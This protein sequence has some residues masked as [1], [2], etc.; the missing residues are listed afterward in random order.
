MQR[1]KGLLLSVFV[2]VSMFTT[3]PV[4][5]YAEGSSDA[6]QVLEYEVLEDDTIKITQYDSLDKCYDIP[7]TI[8]GK[9]V[10][11]I[12]KKA[13]AGCHVLTSVTIPDTVITI[14]NNAFEKCDKLTNVV[15]GNSVKTLGYRAFADNK[16]L[17][18]INLPEGLTTIDNN[19]FIRC[20]KLESIKIPDSVSLIG[21]SAFSD[22][23]GL[24]T[25]NFGNGETT[26]GESAF[27]W[28]LAL[29]E[30]I[31]SKNTVEIKDNAFVACDNVKK[32]T[33]ESD[34]CIIFDGINTL[35]E[36]TV[37]YAYEGSTAN[38]YAI[39]YERKF[40]AIGNDSKNNLGDVD[41]DGKVT[42]LDATRIQL[43]LADIK[44][45]D[46][47]SLNNADVDGDGIVTILDA[48]KIQI[49]LAQLI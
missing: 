16:V 32:F 10:T 33:I 39:K 9:K 37:I 48:T 1:I 20:F 41:L 23:T 44:T 28:C 25:A 4:T 17:K 45:L 13:F 34:D 35:P 14:E 2:L 18:T 8:D 24:K 12:G 29:T 26:I 5:V 22:C 15:L 42:I 27:G 31:V 43:H 40:S 38:S 49:I 47:E 11:V 21:N 6:L 30:I 46:S 7:S 3:L 36:N 19:C